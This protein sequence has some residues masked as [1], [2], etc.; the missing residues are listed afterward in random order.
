M[1]TNNKIKFLKNITGFLKI[2][3][4]F[5][6][7]FLWAVNIIIAISTYKTYYFEI[8]N[9]QISGN[10]YQNYF[11]ILF[12]LSFTI[13]AIIGLFYF[14]FIIYSIKIKTLKILLLSFHLPFIFI[15]SLILVS[16]I[17]LFNRQLIRQLS[18]IFSNAYLS[19]YIIFICFNFIFLLYIPL[20]VKNLNDYTFF[21]QY[22]FQIGA[23]FNKV[24]LS[25][26]WLNFYYQIFI[27]IFI[28]KSKSKAATFYQVSLYKN[29]SI[30]NG[31]RTQ[32][33][34]VNGILNM[35]IFVLPIIVSSIVPLVSN[36]KT[37]STTQIIFG[38]TLGSAV[39][40]AISFLGWILS[41]NKK[42]YRISNFNNYY[43]KSLKETEVF[44]DQSNVKKNLL[45]V[46]EKVYLELFNFYKMNKHDKL[47]FMNS[48]M[49]FCKFHNYNDEW[50]LLDPYAIFDKFFPNESNHFKN[51]ENNMFVPYKVISDHIDF[52]MNLTKND[53]LFLI[54]TI[55]DYKEQ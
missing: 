50:T 32:R 9:L 4:L 26:S 16:E 20:L 5:F 37:D 6:I 44:N 27:L 28:L 43:F 17:F 48:L 12:A 25:A 13:L 34:L 47:F 22:N 46:E 7:L 21:N 1:V 31:F 18:L 41:Y 30:L 51:S 39:S 11:Q 24:D 40:G 45:L 19:F 29:I 52:T 23:K 15:F 10:I 38:V 14:L 54:N 42:T 35:I 53:I 49:K 36:Y 33:N 2:I 3:F 55:K 8:S